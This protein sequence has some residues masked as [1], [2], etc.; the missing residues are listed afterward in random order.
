M[1]AVKYFGIREYDWLG[2]KGKSSISE[3]TMFTCHKKFGII[4][5]QQ[6][7]LTLHFINGFF[8]NNALLIPPKHFFPI[9]R[10]LMWFAFGA[11]A[12]REA[13]IDGETWGTELRKERPVEGRF[14][15]MSAGILFSELVL[16][17]KYREG[18]GHL[19]DAPTPIYKWLPWTIALF[20]MVGFWYYLRN[21]KDRTVMYPGID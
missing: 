9:A 16:A 15:W 12:H 3:W 11:V 21:K 17:Y 19:I 2:R 5:Y 20:A 8:V 13:Y 7:L 1:L 4:F 14:R 18:T 10:L 6:F